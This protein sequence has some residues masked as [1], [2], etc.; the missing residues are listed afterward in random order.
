M[1]GDIEKEIAE[2]VAENDNGKVSPSTL[3]DA[4][5]VVMRGKLIAR[6]AYRKKLNRKGLKVYKQI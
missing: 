6:A 3:W 1:K 5:K 2:H 4:C